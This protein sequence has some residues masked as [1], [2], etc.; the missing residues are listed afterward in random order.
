MGVLHD[1]AFLDLAVFLEKA[2]DFGLR[3]AGVNSGDE[4]VGTRV[5][6]TIFVLAAILL[7]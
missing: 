7:L 3:E 6:G 5:N 4:E 2:G 1:L